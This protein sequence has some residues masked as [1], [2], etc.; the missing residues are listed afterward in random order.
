MNRKDAIRLLA[1]GWA[2]GLARP[3]AGAETERRPGRAGDQEAE[4]L[5]QG[6]R[7]VN[8]DGIREADVRIVGE[9]IAELGPALR[10]GPGARRIDARGKLVLPGGIDPHTHILPPFAD[11]P[12]T[13]TA[14]A[15]AGGITTV[16][17]FAFPRR[18]EDPLAALDRVTAEVERLAIGD[19]FLHAAAWP[20][21]PDFTASMAELASRG[22]PSAKIF[23]LRNDFAAHVPEVIR[24]LEAAREAGV[25]TLIHCEDAALLEAAVGRLEAEGRTSLRYFAESR[26]VLAEVA[27]VQQAVALCEWTRAPMQIVHLSSARALDACRAARRDGLPLFVETR[28]LYL[29]STAERFRSDEGPLFVGQ[30]P[31]RSDRDREALW[32]GLLDGA[33]D[34]LATD[35][36]PWTRAQKMDPTLSITNL[37]P[38]ASALRFMLPLYFSEGVRKRG[39]AL[40]RFVET[41]S[42]AAARIH[43][44]YPVRGVVADGS[45]ADVVV[46][47]PERTEVVR[48]ADDPSNSDY[49]VYEGWEVTGWPV[50]T[51]RRGEVVFE[52]GRVTGEPGTGRVVGRRPW[53]P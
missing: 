51:I 34:L 48:A 9:R 29:H 41:T 22:Q 20:P 31:L 16:G 38:G 10:P 5:V 13:G 37:R 44:L 1:A 23:M 8:A 28:P 2:G 53:R 50:L 24:Q 36:A 40:E 49:A 45:L 25:V 30:P 43:G 7:V 47:D 3:L 17:T 11:D 15:L 42:T 19:V 46:F 21:T 6:G 14:A 39:M 32:A 27:A 33:V 12:A 26:P 4:I 52:D 35:H 18:D